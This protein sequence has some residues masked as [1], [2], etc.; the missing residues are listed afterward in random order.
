MEKFWIGFTAYMVLSLFL[1]AFAFGGPIAAHL[2]YADVAKGL[3][4]AGAP[5]CHQWVYRSYCIF[6]TGSAWLL[7]ECIPHS[8][9]GTVTVRTMFTPASHA[10]DGIFSYSTSQLG[11]NRGEMV[12]RDGMVGY[13]LVVCSRDT[14][15][16]LG[17][18]FAGIAFL[19]IRRH[20]RETP[21]L[22]LLLIGLMPMGIDGT[23]QLLGLWESTNT[24]RSL[25]GFVA[26]AFVGFYLI[27]LLSDIIAKYDSRREIRK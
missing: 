1:V 16:Y 9:N 17:M 11:R 5:L 21:S 6:S 2:G 26:G 7:E 3:Y 4:T 10:W 19:Y 25:T 20:I 22:W 27:S 24:I 12:E 13:K 8:H 15:I 23:G 14:A 18:V